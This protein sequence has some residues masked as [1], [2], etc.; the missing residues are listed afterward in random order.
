MHTKERS[1][2][3]G[4]MPKPE[5]RGMEQRR[6]GHEVFRETFGRGKRQSG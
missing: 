2:V 1:K 3:I 6:A 4:R 5:T